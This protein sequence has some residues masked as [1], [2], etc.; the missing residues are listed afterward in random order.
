MMQP[1]A[2]DLFRKMCSDQ[3]KEKNLADRKVRAALG[4]VDELSE[5]REGGKKRK[6]KEVM[7]SELGSGACEHGYGLDP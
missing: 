1:T 7:S 5:I 4:Y 3:R 6:K 2:A